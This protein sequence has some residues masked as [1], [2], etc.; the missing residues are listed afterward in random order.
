M[1]QADNA[2]TR[3]FSPANDC[4]RVICHILITTAYFSFKI[5]ELTLEIL[6]N[7]SAMPLR[8]FNDLEENAGGG[9][10]F[11]FN[12]NPLQVSALFKG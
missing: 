9:Q 7:T 5:A 3:Q 11:V 12:P 1:S 2:K 10:S 6:W 8:C 4:L